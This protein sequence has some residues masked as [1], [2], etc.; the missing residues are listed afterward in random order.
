MRGVGLLLALTAAPWCAAPAL[1]QTPDT[2]PS[3]SRIWRWTVTNVTRFESWHFFDPPPSGGDPTY[4]FL[5][6]RLR[7]GV[8]LTR[9][10]VEASAGLHYVQFAGLPERAV[11]PGPLGTGALY[12]EHSGRTASRGVSLRTLSLRLRLPGGASLQA[13]RFGYTS[14][15]ESPSGHPRIE[16]VK[17]ARLDAR[18]VGEFE[19]SLYQRSFDGV[20]GDLDR[21]GWH[22]TAAWLRPTQGGFED[23]A[24]VQIRDIDVESLTLTL[25]PGTLVPATDVAVFAHRYDDH[26]PVTA[27]PDN[28][29]LR[30]TRADVGVTTIGVSVVGAQAGRAG[31][32]DWLGWLAVQR[33]TW[34]GLS[35]RAWSLA[36]EGGHQWRAA[37][38]PWLR[39]GYLYASGDADGADGRHGTFFPMLPTV[40]RYA[41][42]TAYAP[43]NLEDAFTELVVRPTA[44]MTV[45]MDARRL[46]LAEAADL[47]YAG[48]GATRRE[49]SYFGYAGRPSGRHRDL[50]VVVEGAADV[51][52][53]RSWSINGFLGGVRGGRVPRTSFPGRWLRF[54]YL[55]QVI[56]F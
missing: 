18:L 34:Y 46:R 36:V 2:A 1:G 10:R 13:G 21:R 33:G 56:R 51:A 41:L 9:G 22:L 40:R 16:A 4:A 55:E 43:M 12:Y 26:R 15:A 19:W 32:A 24:G 44:R 23:E 8:T 5:A 7:A 48:S 14:G 50:G 31:E 35:H 11:G 6:N 28:S 29:G 37:W 45:R 25:R 42:T 3:A 17:R 54:A 30:A 39:G 27:R 20:R 47:W 52:I 53:S 38:E 49:G